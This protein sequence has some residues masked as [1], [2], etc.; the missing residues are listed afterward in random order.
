MGVTCSHVTQIR[1]AINYKPSCVH[2]YIQNNVCIHTWLS[3]NLCIARNLLYFPTN[4]SLAFTN[5]TCIYSVSSCQSTLSID[6]YYVTIFGSGF[7]L[8]DWC[9]M[10]MWWHWTNWSVYYYPGTVYAHVL[11]KMYTYNYWDLPLVCV[12]L[13][14]VYIQNT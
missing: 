4:D 7:N 13:H 12:S 9:Q 10:I 5:N 3:N 6:T 8:G 1:H 11:Y 2:K 14:K